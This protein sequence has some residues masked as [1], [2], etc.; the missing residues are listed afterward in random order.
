MNARSCLVTIATPDGEGR[1]TPPGGGRTRPARWIEAL[2]VIVAL[3][4][5]CGCSKLTYENWERVEEGMYANEVE[6]ILGEPTFPATDNAWI[7]S[8]DDRGISAAVYF[9]D[10]RVSRK[11]WADVEH[12]MVGSGPHTGDPG[13]TEIIRAWKT[14]Q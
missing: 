11:N 1:H 14:K 5:L 9:E 12:G 6:A 7:Y 13:D 8:D 2:T 4:L 10:D 3:P